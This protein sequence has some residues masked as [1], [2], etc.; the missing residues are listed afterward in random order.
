M[1]GFQGVVPQPPSN[2]GVGSA[3]PSRGMPEWFRK[4]RTTTRKAPPSQLASRKIVESAK[5]GEL[6]DTSESL[7]EDY[8][9]DHNNTPYRWKNKGTLDQEA[10]AKE[11]RVRHK[12][13][14]GVK[15]FPGRLRK[16][17]MAL[18]REAEERKRLEEAATRVAMGLP[19]TSWPEPDLLVDESAPS[20]PPRGE[21]NEYDPLDDPAYLQLDQS[22]LPL[23]EFD[24]AAYE[25][26]TPEEWVAQC[27]KTKTGGFSPY[28]QNAS[29]GWVWM[30]CKV[31]GYESKSHNFILEFTLDD[32]TKKEKQVQRIHLRFEL[33]DAD[34]FAERL[35]AATQRREA[36]KARMRFDH[37]VVQQA[38]SLVKAMQPVTLQGIN[39]KV[40]NGLPSTMQP[41]LLKARTP[42]AV[43]LQ[44]LTKDVIC[45]YT[46]C[47]KRA[48]VL[49]SLDRDHTGAK[50]EQYDTLRLPPVPEPAK[51]PAQGKFPIPMSEVEFETHRYNVSE[52]LYLRR[53]EVCSSLQWMYRVYCDQEGGNGGGLSLTANLGASMK[54]KGKKAETSLSTS[55]ENGLFVDVTVGQHQQ[56][57]QPTR[58]AND[59]VRRSSRSANVSSISSIAPGSGSS[60]ALQLPCQMKA[61]D[62]VQRDQSNR[63]T[64]RLSHDW[65][66]GFAEQLMD[67]MNDISVSGYSFFQSDLEQYTTSP[68]WKLMKSIEVRMRDQLRNI[69]VNSIEEWLKFVQKYSLECM[70]IETEA[71]KQHAIA[72]AKKEEEAAQKKT[73]A[74]KKAKAEAKK[75]KKKKKK[76]KVEEG[77]EGEEGAAAAEVA[78]EVVQEEEEEEVPDRIGPLP[79]V[80]PMLGITP[81]FDTQLVVVHGAVHL[82]PSKQELEATLLRAFDRMSE[83]IRRLPAIEHGL[84]SLLPLNQRPIFDI[85][86]QG[87][88]SGGGVKGAAGVSTEP[89]FDKKLQEARKQVQQM[90]TQAM[91][92]PLELGKLYAHYAFVVGMETGQFVKD[93]EASPPVPLSEDEIKQP[94]FAPHLTDAE[95]VQQRA[96]AAVDVPSLGKYRAQM[97]KLYRV[98]QEVM[99]LSDD[100]QLCA[101]A[102]VDSAGIKQEISTKAKE[103]CT[104]LVIRMIGECRV[105]ANSVTER[106]KAIEARIHEKPANEAEL[107]R[108]RD[109]MVETKVTIEKM[110]KE[111]DEIFRRLDSL[112]EFQHR[113]D[114]EDFKLAWSMRQWP[115]TLENAMLNVEMTLEEEKQK[116][117]DILAAEKEQFDVKLEEI[118][119]GVVE[120]ST[121]GDADNVQKYAEA[122]NFLWDDVMEAKK[123]AQDFNER[124]AVF[125][126]PATEYTALEQLEKDFTPYFN[127]WNMLDEFGSS[128]KQWL[129]GPFLELDAKA[130]DKNV[131]QWNKRGVALGKTLGDASPSS[132]EVAETLK[133]RSKEFMQYLPLISSLASP[134]LE[135][136]HWEHL[137]AKIS[138]KLGKEVKIEGDN[139]ELTLQQLVDMGLATEIELL[140]SVCVGA[141]KEHSLKKNMETMKEEW[142]SV[143][144]LVNAYKETGTH[145][146][147]GIDEIITLLDDHLVKV[148]T[149]RGSPFIKPIEAEC[150]EWEQKLQYAQALLDEWSGCQRTWMYLEPIFG[151]DDIM[152]QMPTE[153]RRF[154]S[155]DALW[156][157][158]MTVTVEEPGF[159]QA[160][161]RKGL[162]EKFQQANVKLEEIS[163]GLST[164]LEQKRLVFPRFFFLSNEE[165][166]E[167]L[168]QSKEPRAV[169][170]HLGKCFEGASKVKFESDLKIS[171]MISPE[172]EKVD[173]KSP[174]DPESKS[175][176]GNVEKWLLEFQI[177]QWDAIKDHMTR[178][179]AA[180]AE[181]GKK[182]TEWLTE[183]PAQVVLGVSQVYWTQDVTRLIIDGGSKALK[184]FVEE[185][186]AQLSDI[187]TL[188]RGG[189]SKLERK[190]IGALVVIDVHAKDT[191]VM[192]VEEGVEQINDFKWQSQLRYYWE[193][194]PQPKE[195]GAPPLTLLA[196]IVNATVRYGY[197]YLGNSMRL[198]I[199]ALTDRCYRTMMGAVGL[200]YGGA[201]EGPAGTG[202]TETVKDLSKAIAIQCVVYNCSDQLDYLAMAKFFKGLAGAGSWCC[203][204][205]FNRITVD[206]LSVVAQQILTINEAKKGWSPTNDKFTFEGTYIKLIPTCAPFIT[207][208]PGYAGRAELPDN[209]KALFRPCAMMVPDYAMIGEIRFISFGFTD[210]RENARKLVQVLQLS[211]EQL[212]SQKHYDYGMRAVNSI[213]VAAGNLRQALGSDPFWSEAKI[214]LRSVNDVNLP[215]FTQ[216]D[217][218]LFKGI[219]AD[220]FTGVELPDPDHG[221]LIP[222]ID[223]VCQQGITVK[224]GLAD[225]A[226]N[227]RMILQCAPNFTKKVVQLYE[228]I[229]V[230]HGLTI[231]GETFAGKTC[232]VH[233]LAKAL[234]LCQERGS[235]AVQ[236]VQVFTMNPKSIL[237]GQLYGRFDPN[238]HEWS[239]GILAV[240]YRDA[241]KDTS[242]DR[243]WV[244][245]DGPIDAVW[246]ENMNTVLDDNKKLCLMSGEI[247]KMSDTMTMMFEAEDLQ[248]ASPATVSRVGIVY[249]EPRNLGWHVLL[250]SW[251][252]MQLPSLGWAE[253]SLVP[254][255]EFITSLFDWLLPPAL[256]FV[257]KFCMKPVPVTFMEL[258]MSCIRLLD[259]LL[260]CPHGLGSNIEKAIEGFFI[261]A[262]TWSVGACVNPE[263]RLK[264][265]EYLRILVAGE[266]ADSAEHTD[267]LKKSPKYEETTATE[268]HAMGCALP[269]GSVYDFKWDGKKLSWSNWMDLADHFSIPRGAGFNSILVPTVDTERHNFLIAQLL[270]HGYH[271]L[272]SG[273]TGTGKSAS[274]NRKLLTGLD[275]KY[276]SNFVNFS[277]QT[278]CNQTQDIV[279]SK[280]AKRR[281]GVLGPPLGEVAIFFVDDL[282]MPKK[283]E[284]GAQ[285]PI[286]IL[287]QWM[288]HGGW[289]NREENTFRTLI[290]VQFMAAMGPPG[291]GRN[292]ITQRYIRHFN[293]VNFVPFSQDAL[294]SVFGTI[295]D[296]FL[297]SF[298]GP[299]K[300]AGAP[301]VQAT[302]GIYNRIA[303]ELL[304]TPA[305]SHYTFNLRDLSKVIQGV[306]Q[307]DKDT[308][309][310]GPDLIRL[311]S[312]ECMRVFHDRLIDEPDREWFKTALG[313]TVKQNFSLDY[314]TK[315]RG[316]NETLI[317]GNFI[318]PKNPKRPYVEIGDHEQL[319]QVMND[320]LKDYNETS[321]SGKM[322]LVLFMNAIEH[323]ARISRVL[324][325]PSGNAL[326]VGVGGS[327]RK[328]LTTLS[329]HL[330]EYKIFQIQISKTYGLVEWGDDL[331]K[332]LMMAGMDNE[333]TVFLFSDTQIKMESFVEDVNGIL[334]TGE[335]ANLFNNEDITAILEAVGP[336]A[337]DAGMNAGNP[338]EVYSYF[339]SRCRSNLHVVLALSPIG[340]A[341]RTRLR[342]FPS[343]VN[344][345]TIDW[346]TKWPEEALRS[347]A[348]FFFGEIEIT[349][350]VRQ[351]CID[352]C[353]TMQST[354]GT[355]SEEF[356][357][358]LGRHYYVTPTSYLELIN[359]FKSLL[360]QQR[361]QI[362][363]AKDRYDNG[364]K[365]LGE[366][367][368]QVATMKE[369]L[370]ALQ[371]KL[372][373]ATK[374]TDELIIVIT[375]EQKEADEKKAFVAK[376]EALCA[377]Q[378]EEAGAMKADCEKDLAEAIPALEAAVKALKGL[379]KADITEL[380]GNK[381]PVPNV[382]LVMEA[383]CIMMA[384]KPEKIKDP[385]GGMKK[386][387]DYWGPAVKHLL[388]DP[389]LIP[390]LMAYDKDNIPDDILEKV[391]TYTTNENFK[392][393]VIKKSSVACEGLCKWTNAMVVYDRVAKVVAP[394]TAS[395]AQAEGDLK[396]A[397]TQL[398]AK[399]DML[400]DVIAKV[401][402][403]QK[404]L[405]EAMAKKTALANQ[406]Q[407]CSDKLKRAKSLIDGLGGEKIRWRELS[408]ELQKTYDNVTGDIM[409]SAGVIAYLGAFTVQYRNQS[410]DAWSKVLASKN[411]TCSQTFSL[412]ATLGEPVQIR[413][414]ALYKLPNDSF[415]IENA[416]MMVSS[417]RWPLMI[418]PQE[419]A[420]KW[421]KNMEADNGLKVVKQA[422]SSFVRTIENC[423]SY[424]TPVL[425]E[426][427]P[428]AIDPVLQSV[429]L[430]Q[431]VNRGG[432]DTIKIGDNEVEYDKNFKFYIT[433]KLQ[434]PHYP[435]ETCVMVQ[436]LNFV[437]T[438]DGLQD[439]MLGTVVEKEKAE[440]EK[441]RVQM[442]IEDAENKKQLKEIEDT[443]LR[444]L[445]E[446]KG[447]ILDDETLINTL[448][449]SKVTSNKIEIKVKEAEKTAVVIAKTRKSFT[450][451]AFRV[452][453]LFFTI[454]DLAGVDPM[455]QYSLEWFIDLFKKSIDKAE[456]ANQLEERL[457]SLNASFTSTL[458]LNVCMSLFEKDK[459]LFSFLLCL[460]IMTGQGKLDPSQIRFFMQGNTRMGLEQANP[461]ANSWLTDKIWGEILALSKFKVFDHLPADFKQMP[462]GLA[463]YEAVYNSN[464][465]AAEVDKILGVE[466]EDYEKFKRFDRLC[467]L[468]CLRPD[469][470]VPAIML[471]V[472]EEMG[473]KFIEPPPF[474]LRAG[475]EDSKCDTP[476][477]FVLTPGADPMT[478]LKKLADAESMT[479]E[480]L[481]PISLGQGQGPL[482]EKAI[483]LAVDKGW[484]VCLQNCHLC[485]AWMPE[486]EKICEEITP[487][488]TDEN[489]R[490]WLTS[491]P[492]KAFPQY[493]L[494]NGVKMTNEPPKGMRANLMGSY[495]V[496]TDDWLEECQHPKFLAKMLFGLCFFH[497][498]VRE[499]R[500][501]GPL[502]WNIQYVFSG[503]DLDISR[504]QLK[505]FLNEMQG[506]DPVPYEA[507]R[508]LGGQCNYGG[509]VTDD[510]D[511]RL[512]GSIL[513]GFYCDEIQLDDYKFSESGTYYAPPKT[514]IEGYRDYIKQLPFSEGPEVFGLH[515]NA[516]ISA[517][518]GETQLLLST[519]LSLLPRDQGG[520]GES[521]DDQLRGLASG[522]EGKMPK[523]FDT[524]RAEIDFP[525]KY[526]DSMNTVITQELARFNTLIVRIAETLKEVQKALKGLVVMSG[527]LEAMGNSMVTG[528]VPSLWSVVSYASLKP[529]GGWVDDLLKRLQFFQ[530]WIDELK[531]PASFWV[532]GFFFTQAFIT[533]SKQNYAR[534]YK[535]PIDLVDYDNTVLTEAESAAVTT[536]PEDGAYLHGLYI[537]GCRWD[538]KAKCLNESLPKVLFEPFPTIHL[539]PRKASDIEPV[540][541]TDPN[542]THHVYRC[543]VYKT[544]FRQGALSTSGHS[545]NFVMFYKVP[546]L[547]QHRQ[548]HWIKRGVAMLTQLD[549]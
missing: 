254:Q 304:P 420:N 183:W 535:V 200:G 344:C 248:E 313:E 104:A 380:K 190:T 497:A 528:Q 449:E 59:N 9:V 72:K 467:L 40:V 95:L 369:E 154:K 280:L 91:A 495:H 146:I 521:W 223:E 473:Q 206:V 192:M 462:A 55:L 514:D 387:N 541:D 239:D 13:L 46:H 496:L 79:A 300:Q 161:D 4:H 320:Y 140:Q 345:C 549:D 125:G 374:E 433:T 256:Y 3:R 527:E 120:F 184:G 519:A 84:L 428:E 30:P 224:N 410:V 113:I 346:F 391:K 359:T 406:V 243:K 39:D 312:H 197:E 508:Y 28:W 195:K 236:K 479:G 118:E 340:D 284:Y 204:D 132:A 315:V 11:D 411:I 271:M 145:L 330:V 157:K 510:K 486:L 147:G 424:G 82:S 6:N 170:P 214:V 436:L 395:L 460:K 232:V 538:E 56:Q 43:L 447:N 242:K 73:E 325:Q 262:L 445:K 503:P 57:H 546:M 515:D 489:F 526:E 107:Q 80:F 389:K 474:N 54:R 251:I 208:N 507:L 303:K 332:V 413:Q 540:E 531:P 65:H 264:F 465:P 265:N 76:P 430:R 539:L 417:K 259:C 182:R 279:D 18:R 367:E 396:E 96:K 152:R 343:L 66:R 274:I 305:K 458:Y 227:E 381:N 234:T 530:T 198:V 386:V 1:D 321:Y 203:F 488:S 51:P 316:P 238:T 221:D 112:D 88:A 129:N 85:D 228:M 337:A 407:D 288:D 281:K 455:Y 291:G 5:K 421:I 14:N 418:D 77:M 377:K 308:V 94:G 294:T 233:T 355:M 492:S 482:A 341:F 29:D 466:E 188:V 390:R 354:V 69:A 403:L 181:P 277:A 534:K 269:E 240:T 218:P 299:V 423:V 401:A 187:V 376:E 31:T 328:S 167:I 283:E 60:S 144:I 2:D 74:E 171:Q 220:L 414:W 504:N 545:T 282:N 490:L 290:D 153:A 502:G 409:L 63:L 115:Q 186:N 105:H 108:L 348:T 378:A 548:R 209:L 425:L 385:A 20:L 247:V 478:E 33:E 357:E 97:R 253:D 106:Y 212:S 131:K 427:A 101:L 34:A 448:A 461:A 199:T 408:A 371:P 16:S 533:G 36:A 494:Q 12:N 226:P 213:L 116:M 457:E 435:P 297:N 257:D 210:A 260:D 388:S 24:S 270:E 338:V 426:N 505:I 301:M 432:V 100:Q 314:K 45:G 266:I 444:L 405:D 158:N 285:P 156:R 276:K 138:T 477:I 176:R 364:L 310:L 543:P 180:Y 217:L 278:Q 318:D 114:A 323:V 439:Q 92:G 379:S 351:G 121:Y 235:D 394:K 525:T 165:L 296:W 216:D 366:T 86:R 175:N 464:D 21:D 163:K 358:A 134:A 119:K 229:L 123:T 90:V 127:L 128:K 148:Q 263:G 399:Q 509:R 83:S 333:P 524:E 500:K 211:S 484:W 27:K 35:E 470:V 498:T 17:K 356:L 58:P 347:V 476:I 81:L 370:V 166:L 438:A 75:N 169:Q 111:V 397:S 468:R 172:G 215:K 335:V 292:H 452:S 26:H 487:L 537:E 317:Y 174:V 49:Q 61:F 149:M 349:D 326:L 168:S 431:V 331:K 193:E 15:Q 38:N 19:E 252:E 350:D 471:F 512:L 450:P 516:N 245:F 472:K 353:V 231:V 23:H 179:I 520:G 219:T 517:A 194:D 110:T 536:K 136:R 130:I 103:L 384:V 365:K 298:A 523:V 102:R 392:P 124:E 173:L 273:D 205:E 201:P 499:R 416:I 480:K 155:V 272:C 178:S 189:L 185:L 275:A 481:K 70:P 372:V 434:N 202:K 429:L 48:V 151:S 22:K 451:V 159:M 10:I 398:K 196:R 324:A 37:F 361:D 117:M 141:E 532:N 506:G 311:W 98:S 287:R 419:Q 491:E 422:Q 485:E 440:M 441:K 71:H 67:Q 89:V 493:I 336:D 513:E 322:E 368:A 135:E 375:K 241:S 437:A 261:M 64:E 302:I 137:S 402:A 352:T 230:R 249:L 42:Q 250:E 456:P 327:G 164:Y 501:F 41:D 362:M 412:Q 244:M 454:S 443:I 382:K 459:L 446:A 511:R 483:D 25:S 309:K 191:I 518:N 289:Y 319:R 237:P 62:R 363:G 442:V 334:N 307:A 99:S 469:A 78:E 44:V 267:F 7:T 293:M 393:E 268:E 329:A 52:G 93:F 342:M 126:F 306:Q 522:I 47:M 383:V 50:R 222:T 542:G 225:T 160:A 404:G 122:A 142:G 547:E 53:R 258:G 150:K 109:Y 339:V 162:L 177:S 415:S 32:G 544:S 133:D 475:Y 400:A 373:V 68:L 286:E 453:Q 255:V 463:K 529:L 246:I 87:I 139:E 207:M 360:Q 143:E 8:K 295:V